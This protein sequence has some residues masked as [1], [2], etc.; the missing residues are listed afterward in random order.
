MAKKSKSVRLCC[1]ELTKAVQYKNATIHVVKRDLFTL[2]IG[3]IQKSP[4]SASL[5]LKKLMKAMLPEGKSPS[6][7]PHSSGKIP[8]VVP[9]RYCP[10]CGKQIRK[11]LLIDWA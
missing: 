9:I 1:E 8:V 4:Q 5:A 2:Y 7:P 10:F 3:N 6:I 11:D